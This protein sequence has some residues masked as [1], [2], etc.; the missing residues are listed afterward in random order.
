MDSCKVCNAQKELGKHQICLDCSLENLNSFE[1]SGTFQKSTAADGRIVFR[2][3][4][5]VRPSY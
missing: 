2:P 3:K 4:D 1:L 5:G